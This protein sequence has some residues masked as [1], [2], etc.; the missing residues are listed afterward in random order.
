[1]TSLK[2]KNLDKALKENVLEKKKPILGICLGLQ[3]LGDSSCEGAVEGLGIIKGS[4]VPLE[5]KIGS[6]SKLPHTGWNKV[7]IIR[8]QTFFRKLGNSP[9]FYFNHSYHFIPKDKRNILGVADELIEINS[10]IR[11]EHIFGVQFHPEKSYEF[12]RL[13]FEIFNSYDA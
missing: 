3:L 4:S 5:T 7:K 11:S 2:S 12:G 8:D 6:T 10:I 9:S 13:L 1:M